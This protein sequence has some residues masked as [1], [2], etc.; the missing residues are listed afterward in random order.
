MTLTLAHFLASTHLARPPLNR[1]RGPSSA[2]IFLKPS[3]TPLYT[4]SP[5]RACDC[6]RVLTTS[7]CE[8][9]HADLLTCWSRE[10][11]RGHA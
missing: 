4:V 10:V 9:G 6:S 2:R 8:R 1:A 11:R 7:D 3:N 5:A